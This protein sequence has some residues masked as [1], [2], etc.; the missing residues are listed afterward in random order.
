MNKAFFILIF[1][2][3]TT[4]NVVAGVELLG[5]VNLG[6]LNFENV[7]NSFESISKG[8][9]LSGR[10]TYTTGR[11]QIGVGVNRATNSATLDAKSGKSSEIKYDHLYYGPV[12]AYLVSAK[13]RLDFEYYTDSTLEFKSVDE[14]SN[15]VFS[16]ADKIFGNGFGLGVSFLRGHFISQ[17]LY[18]S[19]SVRRIEIS[20]EEFGADSDEAS[21]F[22]I[23]TIAVRFGILF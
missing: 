11:F 13:L 21:Q 15:S 20:D 2:F 14:Q 23:Q 12:I 6:R 10:G 17:I 4:T 16:K 3:L 5:G 19:F 7:D 1:S 8:L 22:V 9:H 18:Q